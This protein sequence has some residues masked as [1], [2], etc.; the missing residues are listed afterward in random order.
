MPDTLARPTAS[1]NS[2]VEDQRKGMNSER[3][4]T[5]I[6]SL[7]Y[8]E[9]D[10]ISLLGKI[11]SSF[12]NLDPK[13]INQGTF[14][15]MGEEYVKE[16]EA[17]ER[18]RELAIE[19]SY[20]PFHRHYELNGDRRIIPMKTKSAKVVQQNPKG[21]YVVDAVCAKSC[22]GDLAANDPDLNALRENLTLDDF[23]APISN[24]RDGGLM[25]ETKDLVLP[26]KVKAGGKTQKSDGKIY[27]MGI[28][29]ILQQFNTRK[30]LEARY[31]KITGGEKG[32]SCVHHEVYADRFVE[33]FDEYTLASDSA[34]GLEHD[35]GLEEIVFEATR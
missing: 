22:L 25:M 21:K 2:P 4:V 30:R 17:I 20:W 6:G 13:S 1:S 31:R 11:G 27:Y 34:K 15:T 9:D 32:A 33:F 18:R 7:P 16:R 10:E 26:L 5:S 23:V 19:Q 3:S 12:R 8:D 14:D 24:R 35:G 28:I 29:D